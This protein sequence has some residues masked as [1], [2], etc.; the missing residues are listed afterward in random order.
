MTNENSHGFKFTDRVRVEWD[1]EISTVLRGRVIRTGKKF[2]DVLF[3]EYTEN[4][5]VGLKGIQ[6]FT[7]RKGG[8][9]I[10]AKWH[11]VLGIPVLVKDVSTS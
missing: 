6:R 3:D 11:W 9:M 4:Q 8:L 7:L 10:A 2:V 5:R 1:I